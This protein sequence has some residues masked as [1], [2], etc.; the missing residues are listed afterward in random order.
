MSFAYTP[1]PAQNWE[2][3]AHQ[4]FTGERTALSIIDAVRKA[5][6]KLTVSSTGHLMLTGER[7]PQ[8]LFEGLQAKRDEIT[9]VLA[10]QKEQKERTAEVVAA[11]TNTGEFVETRKEYLRCVACGHMR[12]QHC[13]DFRKR[14][15]WKSGAWKGFRD[16]EGQIQAC[17]HMEAAGGGTTYMCD[18]A[19]CALRLDDDHYCP[20]QKFL[21]PNAKKRVPKTRKSCTLAPTEITC[22]TLIPH[23][24]L[25]AA[26]RRFV[27]EEALKTKESQLLAF[28]ASEPDIALLPVKQIAEITGM[29][30]TQ[31]R[32]VLKKIGVSLPWAV[33]EETAFT[34]GVNP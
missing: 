5:R 20:C 12:C 30:Q 25:I 28:A 24:D 17:Q 15:K 1:R 4:N 21:S 23:E 18:S 19:A 14:K 31:I 13:T 26:N 9:A 11:P 34:T 6:G 3:R 16:D 2:Q 22:R 27:R 7:I 32:Q 8:E 33:R 29:T 10:T